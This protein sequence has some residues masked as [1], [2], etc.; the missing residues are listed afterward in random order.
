KLLIHIEAKQVDRSLIITIAD[1]GVGMTPE[2]IASVLQEKEPE[3][4][5]YNRIGL[6][7]V[8]QR[9]RLNH[10]DNYGLTITSI[11]GQGTSIVLELPIISA[12]KE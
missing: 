1:N 12:N 9:I 3:G 8:H 5:T 4:D 11:V 10:G 7:N 2:Q 6:Y